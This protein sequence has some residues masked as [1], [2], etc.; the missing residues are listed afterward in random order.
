MDRKDVIALASAA[1]FGKLLT[2]DGL[3]TMWHG[4]DLETL[5]R[6]AELVAD[7]ERE[8]CAQSAEGFTEHRDDRQWVPGSLYDTLRRETAAAIRKRSN[9][10]AQA[11]TAGASRGAP[12]GA[13]DDSQG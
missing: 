12:S 9:A 10:S 3:P 7:K 8:A 2:G 11:R 1:G 13:P 4:A 5:V 6:F